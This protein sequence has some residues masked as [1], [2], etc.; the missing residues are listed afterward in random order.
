MTAETIEEIGDADAARSEVYAAL[1][2]AIEFPSVEFHADVS[3]GAFAA[4]IEALVGALPYALAQPPDYAALVDDGGY[5]DFQAEYIRLF[6]VGT[7]RPPCPLYGGEWTGARKQAMEET[8]RF[9]RFFG[10]KVDEAAREL[11]DH[12]TVELEFLQVMAFTEGLARARGGDA[13]PLLRA[14]RDFLARHPGRWW[15]QLTRKLASC[16]PSPFYAALASLIDSVLAADLAYV[17]TL[18]AA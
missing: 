11:P 13:A 8:L 3:T 7:V 18:L 5:V 17:K 10:M 12:I 9:Y 14:E 2:D 1:A 4:G 6:D 15:P 16:T